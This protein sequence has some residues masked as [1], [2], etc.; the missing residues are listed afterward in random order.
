VTRTGRAVRATF[1]SSS[2]AY[3]E[4]RDRRSHDAAT[5]DNPETIY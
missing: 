2:K 1:G 3:Q 4:L 5:D